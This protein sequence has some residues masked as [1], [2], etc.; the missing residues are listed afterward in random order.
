MAASEASATVVGAPAPVEQPGD[1]QLARWI[2]RAA[3]HQTRALAWVREARDPSGRCSPS[4]RRAL[5][6]LALERLLVARELLQRAQRASQDPE[7]L[8]QLDAHLA[9]LVGVV[10]STERMLGRLEERA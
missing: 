7:L 9:R 4:R 2:E 5:L 8:A 10:E 1:E 6:L 3:S